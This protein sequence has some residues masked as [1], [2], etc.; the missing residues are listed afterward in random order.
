MMEDMTPIKF[1][2]M[3]HELLENKAVQPKQAVD[4]VNG[5]CQSCSKSLSCP[6][7]AKL[8]CGGMMMMCNQ[9]QPYKDGRFR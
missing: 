9:Y 7:L 3:L 5:K 8:P 1:L 4:C 2:S 6:I